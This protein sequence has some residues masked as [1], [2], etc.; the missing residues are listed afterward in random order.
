MRSV[1]NLADEAI[2]QRKI[3]P[4]AFHFVRDIAGTAL[5]SAAL[6]TRSSGKL[7]MMATKVGF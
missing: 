1:A 7:L 6:F 4:G 5:H 3:V 2:L